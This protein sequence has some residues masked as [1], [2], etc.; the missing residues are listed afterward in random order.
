MG[1]PRSGIVPRNALRNLTYRHTEMARRLVLGQ[2]QCDVAREFG[3]SQPRMSDIARSPVFIEYMEKL[4]RDRDR[5]T[6]DIRQDVEKGA[7]KGMRFLL[8][9]L[10][11]GTIEHE[12]TTANAKVKVAQ[13]FLDRE[14][15]KPRIRQTQ[16]N[17]PPAGGVVTTE[18]LEQFK[19]RSL[20]GTD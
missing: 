4:N 16:A 10:T 8:R 20:K 12:K 2:R 15:S 19:K 3:I 17:K 18:L 9:C 13:D 6:G 1:R 5:K 11:D 7:S 14:G